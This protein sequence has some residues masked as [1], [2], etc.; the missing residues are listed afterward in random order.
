MFLLFLICIFSSAYAWFFDSVPDIEYFKI[1]MKL[2]GAENDVN[3]L[4]RNFTLFHTGAYG[5]IIRNHLNTIIG[6]ENF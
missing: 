5:T 1:F 4:D 6:L 2:I 3:F